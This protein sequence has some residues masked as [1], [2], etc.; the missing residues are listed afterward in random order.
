MNG[1]NI[2]L[3]SDGTGNSAAKRHKTNVWRL[4][5]ALD[6]SDSAK[7][8]AFYDDGVGTQEFLPFKLL[9]GAF[10]WGLQRNVLELYMALCRTHEEGDR[11][12]LF[13]FS[14]GAFTIRMLAGLI[15][16]RG[17][18]TTYKDED[19]LRKRARQ[20][21][22]DYR[23]R[24]KR[25]LVHRLWRMLRGRGDTQQLNER[26]KID[27]IEFIGAW[28]T[29]DA[30]GFPVSELVSLW[31]Y[32]IWPLRFVDQRLSDKVKRACHALSI[33]DER[34]SFWPVLW[35]EGAPDGCGHEGEGNP[36]QGEYRGEEGRKPHIEQVWFAGVHSDVGGG[37]ARSALALVSLDWMI[38]K[39]EARSIHDPGLRFVSG[40]QADYAQRANCHGAQHD[41]RSGLRAYYRYKPRHIRELC[42]EQGIARPQVHCSVLERVR[43][44][45]ITYAP[46]ALPESYEVVDG[47]GEKTDLYEK[48]SSD[49]MKKAFAY[50]RWRRGLYAV[51]VLASLTF[52]F[53]PLFLPGSPDD[54]CTGWSC[55]AGI[56]FRMVSCVIPN[57]VQPWI[58]GW[59]VVVENPWALLGI[60]VTAVLLWQLKARCFSATRK[61]ATAAWAGLGKKGD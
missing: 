29:V 16:C 37:Y 31:D 39:V 40:N 58:T 2:V 33:D 30:Y 50:T 34:A 57:C 24:Y 36:E 45:I 35:E 61:H 18:C 22:I 20:Q 11:I 23:S 10:G 19:D 27:K 41:S 38:S 55:L 46:T 47:L 13:G 14:R 53:L 26:M 9:G 60:I 1:K 15:A 4:Y 42:C 28:D 7:Q 43:R 5:Q 49:E 3:L 51:F 32:L 44:G 59:I 25:G 56:P 6:L 12:Y 8:I 52:A 48:Y 21:F 54:A 17:V